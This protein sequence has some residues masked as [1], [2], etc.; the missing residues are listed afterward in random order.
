MTTPFVSSTSPGH[1][2]KQVSGYVTLKCHTKY[3]H[4]VHKYNHV[5]IIHPIQTKNWHCEDVSLVDI[6]QTWHDSK[7]FEH[8]IQIVTNKK[9]LMQS[10]LFFSDKS[11]VFKFWRGQVTVLP[12]SVS[13]V[14]AFLSY[15]S[16]KVKNIRVIN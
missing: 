14:T 6:L 13:D 11:H 7:Q 16:V 3:T 5:N 9:T 12:L 2:L 1:F 8:K 4:N 15:R 10:I